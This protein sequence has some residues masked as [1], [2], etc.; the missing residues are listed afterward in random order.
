MSDKYDMKKLLIKIKQLEKE[1][2]NL[3][4][5]L[6]KGDNNE[7]EKSDKQLHSVTEPTSIISSTDTISGSGVRNS[8]RISSRS[9][10]PPKS[11]RVSGR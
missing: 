3:R 2:T 6:D 10:R 4:Q 7:Q 8:D 1:N 11:V 9:I 5:L